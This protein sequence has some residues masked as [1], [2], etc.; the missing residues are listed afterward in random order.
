ML[1]NGF[2]EPLK[3]EVPYNFDPA[4]LEEL[5]K[6]RYKNIVDMIFTCPYIED[7][8]GAKKYYTAESKSH[9]NILNFP[10]TWEEY[11]THIRAIQATGH[12]CC[13]LV[14]DILKPMDS[15][16]LQKYIDL[17]IKVFT[18]TRW[19]VALKIR[20]LCPDARIVGSITRKVSFAEYKND[21]NV[22][23]F[24]EHVLYFPFN[25]CLDRLQDLNN[26]QKYVMLVNCGCS[27]LCP[28]H[29]HWYEDIIGKELK[30]RNG[31]CKEMKR[32]TGILM[33]PQL[34]PQFAKYI[35]KIK[36]QGR[37]YPTNVL[38]S[39]IRN[40]SDIILL[41]STLNL[42]NIANKTT[43][44]YSLVK[45]SEYIQDAVVYNKYPGFTLEDGWAEWNFK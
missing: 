42:D 27:G 3:M 14:Q 18:V 12:D 45:S 9:L 20:E 29:Y 7:H 36:L 2:G 26:K 19:D 13:L 44:S 43:L 37:E 8:N 10:K 25:I 38:I 24:D 21:I 1:L 22:S 16:V 6:P 33:M 23:A 15:A 5:K 41:G 17:G 28:G 34:L 30:E 40:Y 11:V 31:S 4:L 39:D 32:K 35:A